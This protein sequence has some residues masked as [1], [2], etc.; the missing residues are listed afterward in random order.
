[1]AAADAT[2]DATAHIADVADANDANVDT[3]AD[4]A[5]ADTADADADANADAGVDADAKQMQ[6]QIQQ[7]QMIDARRRHRNRFAISMP[8]RGSIDGEKS[9]LRKVAV[10]RKKKEHH[11]LAP[12]VRDLPQRADSCRGRPALAPT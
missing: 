10:P 5:D 1:M 11:A 7:M 2:A 9:V 3:D 6:M 12:P 4:D 8:R